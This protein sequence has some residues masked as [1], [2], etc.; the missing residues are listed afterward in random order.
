MSD[1]QTENYTKLENFINEVNTSLSETLGNQKKT[2]QNIKF[3]L[4]EI[5]DTK[6]ENMQRQ[7]DMELSRVKTKYDEAIVKVDSASKQLSK[8]FK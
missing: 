2:I 6:Q 7:F 1:A 8:L 5:L 3:E 4:V